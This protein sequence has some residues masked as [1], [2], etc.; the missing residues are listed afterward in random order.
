MSDLKTHALSMEEMVVKSW[1][2]LEW[3]SNSFSVASSN[4]NG[5][6][7]S[8]AE[9]REN[10]LLQITLKWNEIKQYTIEEEEEEEHVNVKEI[11][12]RERK[13]T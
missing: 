9:T 5:N 11:E 13:V 1:S 12:I 3:S 4:P 6:S 7:L 10:L 8:I 2:K